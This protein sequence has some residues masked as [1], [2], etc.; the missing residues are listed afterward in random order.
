MR[1]VALLSAIAML[2]VV[3]G[4]AAYA[5]CCP[6]PKAEC[7]TPCPAPKSVC[8]PPCPAPKAVCPA[9]CP[10]AGPAPCAPKPCPAPVCPS[11]QMPCPIPCPAP[12]PVCPPKCCPTPMSA[13]AAQCPCPGATPGALGAGPCG[14]LA[15]L[16]CADFDN[17]YTAKLYDQNNAVIAVTTQGIERSTDQNLRDI[18]G[19]IRTQLTSE[20]VKLRDWHERMGFGVIPVDYGKVQSIV[21]SLCAPMGKC[22]DVAYACQ[23]IGLLEQSKAAHELVAERSGTPEIRQQ[24]EFVIRYT[25]DWIFRLQRWVNEKGQVASA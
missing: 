20:N 6:A 4:T 21:D 1:P 5:Q 10:G 3:A 12:A 23:L 24:A 7:P 17:S 2:L 16:E 22:F 25:C 15:C 11:A 19:E 14:D 18:S 13:P 8:Q 9:P